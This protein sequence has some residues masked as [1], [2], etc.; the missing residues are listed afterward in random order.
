MAANIQDILSQ[1]NELIETIIY[2]CSQFDQTLAILT[3]V[4]KILSELE[5]VLKKCKAKHDVL[6]SYVTSDG[7]KKY[8]DGNSLQKAED[9]VEGIRQKI[10][11]YKAQMS[12]K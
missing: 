12:Q 10:S 8:I 3:P 4:D 2:K 6:L 7:V 1:Q 11:T 5:E 9:S